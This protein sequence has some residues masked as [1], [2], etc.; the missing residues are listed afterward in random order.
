M[1]KQAHKPDKLQQTAP[2]FWT[3]DIRILVL[4]NIVFLGIIIT[5][6]CIM[7]A[8]LKPELAVMMDTGWHRITRGAK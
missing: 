5:G 2:R 1:N 4:I 7:I 6:L 8:A 3:R